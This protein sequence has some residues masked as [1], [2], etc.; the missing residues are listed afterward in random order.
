VEDNVQAVPPSSAPP[1][2]PAPTPPA[3]N[4]KPAR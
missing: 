3:G 4:V 2:S 1:A